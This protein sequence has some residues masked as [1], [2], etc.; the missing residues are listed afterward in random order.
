MPFSQGRLSAAHFKRM[1]LE[2]PS[3]GRVDIG[4]IRNRKSAMWFSVDTASGRAFAVNFADFNGASA[5]GLLEYLEGE[6]AVLIVPEYPW[7]QWHQAHPELSTDAVE[8]LEFDIPLADAAGMSVFLVTATRI[9]SSDLGPGRT[10]PAIVE[11]F[12]VRNDYLALLS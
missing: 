2:G 8:S 6:E 11:D 9:C 3:G 1:I 12:P 10:P 7:S 5:L 4:A